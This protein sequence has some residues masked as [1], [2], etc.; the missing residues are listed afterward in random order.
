MRWSLWL[1]T[2]TGRLGCYNFPGET[3]AGHGSVHKGV[4]GAGS[5]CL[6]QQSKYLEV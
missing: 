6:Q 5:A 2:E 3:W 1:G 4:M